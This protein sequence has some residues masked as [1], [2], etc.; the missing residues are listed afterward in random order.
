MRHMSPA[1]GK[2]SH[3]IHVDP[4][5]SLLAIA[6]TNAEALGKKRLIVFPCFCF[7]CCHVQCSHRPRCLA[8]PC[9]N[10]RRSQSDA[11]PV[12]LGTSVVHR[13]KLFILCLF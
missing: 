5:L 10:S 1:G 4:L 11:L 13:L 6:V 9:F 7:G 3:V 8:T 12:I 2:P